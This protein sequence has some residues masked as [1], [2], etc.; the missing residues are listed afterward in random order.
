MTAPSYVS[1]WKWCAL[2]SLAMVLLS[3]IPQIHFWF[4]RGAEWQG[5]YATLQGDEFLYSAY[6]NSL[7]DG[8]PRRNDPFAGRDSTPQSPLPESTFSIQFIPPYAIALLARAFRVS[9]STAFIVLMGATALLASGALFWLLAAVTGDVRLAAAGVFFVLCL[10]ELAGDQGIVGV[11]LL[12]HKL[13]VF[14]PFLR[15]YQPALAIPFFFIFFALIW[16][17]LSAENKRHAVIYSTLAGFVF[18]VLVFSY[19]YLWTAVA[20]WLTA[21]AALWFIFRPR[22]EKLRSVVVFTITASLMILALVPYALLV[23]GRSRSLD[24]AQILVFTHRLDLFQPP[25]LIGAFVLLALI[26]GARRGKV[27]PS[28]PRSI[29]AASFALL[30]FLVF[31]QQLLTGRSMQPFHFELFVVNYA[32]LISLI[33]LVSLL[34][35]PIPSRALVLIAALCFSW[36]ILEVSLLARARTASDVVDDQTVPVL[37]RLKELARGDGTLA[38]LRNSGKAPVLVFS[39]S[40]NV[41]KLLPTWTSQGTLL[42]AG[43]QDFGSATR[44]DRKELL[45]IQLYY[46]GADAARFREL[47]N[48]RTEDSYMNFYAPS[49]IFGDQ[50]FIPALSINSVPIQREE[51]EAEVRGYQTY[52]DSFAREQVMQHPLAYVII[53]VEGEPGLSHID[54]WYERDAGEQ[55]GAYILYRLKLRG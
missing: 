25:E 10:G 55:V 36:A 5:A 53:R 33:I 22:E 50:R 17:A 29:F 16:R 15:R 18:G 6:V 27:E 52:V 44:S 31:N 46:S 20:A 21:L 51:I 23:A 48:Q 54:R 2:V 12:H 42:G 43:A 24:D 38:E 30:P 32:V 45:Y 39:P 1:G 28:D 26:L 11:L 40:V 14:M 41:M 34:W 47:L 9:A 8:R 7:I 35:Q 19:L 3:L 4:V 13:S 49:V 37:L